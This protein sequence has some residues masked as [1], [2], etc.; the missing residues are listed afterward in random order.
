MQDFDGLFGF[1]AM[2]PVILVQIPVTSRSP[3]GQK[4]LLLI[5]IRLLLQPLQMG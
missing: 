4:H 2:H 5:K 1:M 3:S